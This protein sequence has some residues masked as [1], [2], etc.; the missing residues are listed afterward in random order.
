MRE[1]HFSISIN[2]SKE[3]VWKTLWEDNTFRDWSS[4]IDEGTFMQGEMKEGEAIQFI[5]SINGYGVTSTIE[6]MIENQYIK[7]KHQADTIDSG[8]DTREIE[9]TG[10]T[11][12]YSL[13]EVDNITVLTVNMDVPLHQE[14]TFKELIPLALKR[15]KELSEINI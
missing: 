7:F 9:W 2:A 8:Q 11:E 14:E 6:K 4:I 1:L 12:S 15:I 3:Y 5:S 13:K 10:G